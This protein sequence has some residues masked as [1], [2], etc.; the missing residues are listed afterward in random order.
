MNFNEYN[1][2]NWISADLKEKG[3]K[4]N[5]TRSKIQYFMD[6][7]TKFLNFPIRVNTMYAEAKIDLKTQLVNMS[8]NELNCLNYV[9]IEKD[10]VP[11]VSQEKI[12]IHLKNDAS[13]MILLLQALN[14]TNLID[15]MNKSDL[16]R[17]ISANFTSDKSEDFNIDGIRNR[18]Y[19]KDPKTTNDLII[20]LKNIISILDKNLL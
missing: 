6:L 1:F 5:D 12:K 7:N 17:F 11:K 4:L 9:G 10:K 20:E 15:K 18:L 19:M 13:G 2:L 3:Q 16:A 8:S 14:Q